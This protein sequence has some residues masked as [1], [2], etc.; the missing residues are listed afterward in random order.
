[1]VGNVSRNTLGEIYFAT[2]PG[3][4]FEIMVSELGT[5]ILDLQLN[6]DECLDRWTSGEC[7]NCS[8]YAEQ[9]EPFCR[10][11]GADLKDFMDDE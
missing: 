11:C 1:M 5:L 9:G 4:D 10:D 8:T 3:R 2:R 6:G 7:P